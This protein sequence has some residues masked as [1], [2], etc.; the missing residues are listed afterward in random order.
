MQKDKFVPTNDLIKS[1]MNPNFSISPYLEVHGLDPC[2]QEDLKG[3]ILR[4]S[5][6][7]GVKLEPDEILRCFIFKKKNSKTG[8]KT[9]DTVIVKFANLTKKMKLVEAFKTCDRALVDSNCGEP[10]YLTDELSASTKKLLSITEKIPV[11]NVSS[12]SIPNE[13]KNIVSSPLQNILY[14]VAFH[15][16]FLVFLI[17]INIFFVNN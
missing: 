15:L 9:M 2:K 6:F 5:M 10:V 3:D 17:I 13:G 1:S 11:D 8:E 4:I 12:I 7:F 14:K 16:F